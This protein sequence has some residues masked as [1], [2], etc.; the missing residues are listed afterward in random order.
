M[1]ENTKEEMLR[2]DN[3]KLE[4]SE[5][6]LVADCVSPKIVI[7][8]MNKLIDRRLDGMKFFVPL[9]LTVVTSVIAYL[10]AMKY[11][12]ESLWI[13][14]IVCAYLLLCLSSILIAYFP[15]SN[16]NSTPNNTPKWLKKLRKKLREFYPWDVKSYLYMDSFEFRDSLEEFLERTLTLKE[17]FFANMLYLKISELRYKQK[18]IAISYSIIIAGAFLMIIMLLIAYSAKVFGWFL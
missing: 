7:D 9:L 17:L 6:V 3:E 10:F 14:Y 2:E 5:D 11:S 13:A 1:D 12:K 16:Y 15:K 8:E 18:L 4:E